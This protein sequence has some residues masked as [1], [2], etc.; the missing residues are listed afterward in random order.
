MSRRYT[1]ASLL[2]LEIDDD[3]ANEAT[4]KEPVVKEQPKKE[5]DQKHL[6]SMFDKIANSKTLDELQANWKAIGT[7]AQKDKD[8]LAK[9]EELK[10]IL[11]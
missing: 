10:K 5:V 2:A 3:D 6:D 4:K 9:K 8:I 11:K 7:D 1:L